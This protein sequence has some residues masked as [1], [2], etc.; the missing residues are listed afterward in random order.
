MKGIILAGG[1]G[2]RLW[3]LTK[4]T[5][6]HLL[7][8]YNKQM[9][10][11]PLLTLKNAGIEEILIV[12]GRP[13]VGDFLKLLGSGREF[14][15]KLSYE[16]QEEEIGIANAL[17]LGEDF[18]HG[19]KVVVILGDNIF[20]DNIAKIVQSFKSQKEG[21]Y[22]FLKEVT[23]AHRFGV[24]EIKNGKIIEI[25]EKPKKPKTNLAVTGLYMYDN[26]VFDF[27]KNLKPSNRGEF[28]IT[29]VNNF[30]IKRSTMKYNILKGKWTDAGTFE[31]LLKASNLARKLTLKK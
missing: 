7:P 5:N 29:D 24:A 21:S 26:T 9:I 10:F 18:A 2:T 11:Y 23:D 28:E 27:I 16:I 17:S 30:Y 3:P 8:I 14:G 19:E 4:I 22:V 31:S 15:V 1:K 6:K 25:V 12:S 20:E 13:H